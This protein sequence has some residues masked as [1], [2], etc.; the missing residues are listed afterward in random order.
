ELRVV[1]KEP[2][3]TVTLDGQELLVGPAEVTRV[4]L[5]GPHQLVATK[6]AFATSTRTVVLVAGRTDEEEIQVDAI[7]PPAHTERRWPTWLPWT[8]LAS[9]A[10]AALGGIPLEIDASARFA[11]YDRAVTA[12][13]PRGCKPDKLESTVLDLKS[14]VQLEHTIAIG[15]FVSGVALV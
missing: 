7:R 4:V 10:V 3:A 11:D 2:G 9:G 5:P 6:A 13:C 15:L 12:L 1:C 8:V 14:N